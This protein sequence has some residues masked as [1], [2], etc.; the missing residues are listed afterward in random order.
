MARCQV[1][2][3]CFCGGRPAV[4]FN[5]RWY[6]RCPDCGNCERGAHKEPDLAVEA[7]NRCSLRDEDEVWKVRIEK[8]RNA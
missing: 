5:G 7:W 1:P 4:A 8:G 6:V 3:P 2:V